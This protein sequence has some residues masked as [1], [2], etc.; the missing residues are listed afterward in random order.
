MPKEK[1]VIELDKSQFET[2]LRRGSVVFGGEQGDPLVEIK[3]ENDFNL[4][5]TIQD[6]LYRLVS[7]DD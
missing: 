5:Q 7:V 4:I 6:V 3:V 1:I 2:I